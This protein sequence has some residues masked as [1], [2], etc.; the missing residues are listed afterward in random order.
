MIA[1]KKENLIRMK[2]SWEISRIAEVKRKF[3]IHLR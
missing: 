3:N 1:K 2:C